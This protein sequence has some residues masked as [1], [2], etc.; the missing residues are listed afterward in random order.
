MFFHLSSF[1]SICFSLLRESVLAILS[2]PVTISGM[3]NYLL[4]NLRYQTNA[5][6]D[7]C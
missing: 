5:I 2:S 6:A 4:E 3:K 1:H 7:Q